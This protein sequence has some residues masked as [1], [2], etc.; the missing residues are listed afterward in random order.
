[1]ISHIDHINLVVTDLDRMIDFY[2]ATLGLT[3]TKRVTISGDWIGA[4]DGLTDDHADVIYLDLTQGP[5][6][7]LIRYN[8]PRLDRP[9]NIDRP[10]APGLRHLAFAVHDID[11]IVSRLRTRG[12]KFFSDI[13][14]VPTTQVTYAGGVRKRIVYFQDPEGNLLELCEYR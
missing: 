14:T 7:E 10:H 12:V 11:S 13:Q 2:T 5:R 3:L 9:A 6:L 4:T 1:M 8:T